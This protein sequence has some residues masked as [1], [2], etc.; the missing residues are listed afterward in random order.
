MVL[1]FLFLQIP[2]QPEFDFG[3]SGFVEHPCSV[4]SGDSLRL[5]DIGLSHLGKCILHIMVVG[6]EYQLI[7][8]STVSLHPIC[9]HGGLLR[10]TPFLLVLS[11]F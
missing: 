5:G 4:E 6:C 9:I 8:I 10:L 11:P 7:K 2:L 3:E 1:I